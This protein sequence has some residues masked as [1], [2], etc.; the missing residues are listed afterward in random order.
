MLRLFLSSYSFILAGVGCAFLTQL[1]LA[2][3]L[4]AEEYGVFS[5][6]FSLSLLLS[7]FAL[8]GFQNS[9]VRLIPQLDDANTKRRMIRFANVFT[10]LL[11]IILGA[12]VFGALD[13]IGYDATYS[14]EALSCGVFLTAFMTMMRLRSAFMRGFNKS[15]LSVLFETTLRE[16]GFFIAIAACFLLA[17]PLDSA[18]QVLIIL[19]AIMLVIIIIADV[20]LEKYVP[21]RYRFDD[22]NAL[23]DTHKDWA[24]L[25]FPMML[26]IFAQRFLRRSDIIILGLMVNPALVGAYAIAAQ[27][28][29]VS[30]IGQK[31][32]FAV[33]SSRAAAL[34]KD[35]LLDD[36]RKL[37]GKMQLYGIVVAAV[38]SI[39]IALLA[40]FILQFFGESYGAG[41]HALIILLVGQFIN[42]CFGPVGVL[43]IMT[44][45]EKASMHFT[46]AAAVGNLIF[47][48]VAI[49]FFDLEGAAVVTAFFLVSRAAVSYI[50]VKRKG[51]L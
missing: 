45:Y 34:Y 44:E 48:P 31:G 35:G 4:P 21:G 40:P 28:A 12:L 30:S 38:M 37:Y 43:M 33:F 41:Y 1:A 14:D 6:I 50:F 46:A 16:V 51:L 10:V 39:A 32:V 17:V 24:K 15:T 36:L 3:L 11:A 2:R 23:D 8:F 29:D 26:I 49:W 9:S 22:F 27:F 13:L 19:A 18:F 5:F 47:N 20:L 25:S 42:L 7:V